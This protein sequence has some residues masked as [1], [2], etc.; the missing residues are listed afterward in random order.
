M[1]RMRNRI[2]IAWHVLRGH[3]G[4]YRLTASDGVV[5]IHAGQHTRFVECH[6]PVVLCN[7]EHQHGPSTEHDA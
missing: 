4:A 7:G 5:H 6:I 2:A 3:P 1:R